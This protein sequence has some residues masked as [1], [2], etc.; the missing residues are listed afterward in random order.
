M[1]MK[2]IIL[3]LS[4]ILM[5]I[6]AFSQASQI[7]SRLYAKYSEEDLL[8]IQSNNPT[9]IEYMNWFVENAY[10]IKEIANPETSA[11]PKLRYMDK[12]TKMAGSEA[13]YFNAETFNVMEYDFEIAA[14]SSNAYLIGNTGKVLVFYSSDDLTKLFNEYRRTHYENQ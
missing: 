9:D 8:E 14:K 11:F 3:L 4:L 6:G 5:G 7:D 10:V 13:T 12:E 1:F 2:K